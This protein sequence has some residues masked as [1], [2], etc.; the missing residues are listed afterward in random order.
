MQNE[1]LGGRKRT[2]RSTPHRYE[3]L[4]REFWNTPIVRRAIRSHPRL[5]PGGGATDNATLEKAGRS[6]MQGWKTQDWKTW[7]ET[8]GV[9]NVRLENVG[10]KLQGCKTRGKGMYGQ[11]IVTLYIVVHIQPV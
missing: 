1:S 10:P 7:H 6:K 11:P 9:E 8:A 2:V 5:H 3:V 4:P